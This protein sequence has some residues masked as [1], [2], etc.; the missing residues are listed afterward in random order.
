MYTSTGLFTPTSKVD[1][2]HYTHFIHFRLRLFLFSSASFFTIF[3]NIFFFIT[4]K[5]LFFLFYY[6]IFLG[7]TKYNFFF[8]SLFLSVY[9]PLNGKYNSP[10]LCCCISPLFVKVKG[11]CCVCEYVSFLGYCLWLCS[12][13]I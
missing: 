7:R 4:K 11:P 1:F 3:S 9:S 2:K 8:H 13:G 12:I 6:H 10:K 5:V